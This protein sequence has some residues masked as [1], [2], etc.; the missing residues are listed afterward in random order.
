LFP[1]DSGLH[2]SLST[3]NSSQDEPDHHHIKK[4][5]T[6]LQDCFVLMN[7]ADPGTLT[8]EHEEIVGQ[9][10]GAIFNSICQ[11]VSESRDSLPILYAHSVEF[12]AKVLEKGISQGLQQQVMNDM[13]QFVKFIIVAIMMHSERNVS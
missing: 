13:Q 12:V 9:T 3:E 11:D 1:V 8:K 10:V 6:F 4:S 2:L 7:S 5:L